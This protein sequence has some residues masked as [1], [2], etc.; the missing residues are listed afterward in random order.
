MATKIDFPDELLAAELEAW[1]AIQERRLTVPIAL[2]VHQGIAAYVAR[3]DV[4]V[5][6]LD[7]EMG[8]KKA[9]RHEG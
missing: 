9:V 6:R 4:D 1:T 2:A 7:V 8:L 3:D 5:T